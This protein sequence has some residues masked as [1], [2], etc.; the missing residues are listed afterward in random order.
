MSVRLSGSWW[1]ILL[2]VLSCGGGLEHCM[3]NPWRSVLMPPDWPR[4]SC[5]PLIPAA[6]L[7]LLPGNIIINELSQPIGAEASFPNLHH[8]HRS[9][10]VGARFIEVRRQLGKCVFL[11]SGV[12][13]IKAK[14]WCHR[15]SEGMKAP[16]S[17]RLATP[18]IGHHFNHP[19]FHISHDVLHFI[20][21]RGCVTN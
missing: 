9:T 1:K 21:V 15:S 8:P 13:G 7:V 4:E 6:E 20:K 16:S 10:P 3:D 14:L 12:G 19:I 11:M 17:P 2:T 18:I 5:Y